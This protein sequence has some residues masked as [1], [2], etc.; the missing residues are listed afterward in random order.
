MT[1]SKKALSVLTFSIRAISIMILITIMT[2]DT[3]TV[4]ISIKI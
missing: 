3:A 4:N 2:L 1:P